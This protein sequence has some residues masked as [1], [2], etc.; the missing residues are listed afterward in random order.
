MALYGTK[1]MCHFLPQPL[2]FFLPT[3]AAQFKKSKLNWGILMEEKELEKLAELISAKVVTATKKVLTFDEAMAFTGLS[4]S[5][6]Y[7]LT[8]AKEIPYYKPNGKMVYFDRE[9]IEKW[10]L[11]NRV[12]TT[13]EIKELANQYLE[14]GGKK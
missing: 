10:L 13:T 14:K 1:K 8:S 5:H 9:E 2:F 6:L 7:K 11:T 12:S 4:K 3:F